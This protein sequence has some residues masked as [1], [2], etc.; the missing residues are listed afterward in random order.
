MDDIS[1]L[2]RRSS[3]RERRLGRIRREGGATNLCGLYGGWLAQPKPHL[4]PCRAARLGTSL[5][6]RE[7]LGR[8][9]LRGTRDHMVEGGRPSLRETLQLLLLSDS[10]KNAIE[11]LIKD[12]HRLVQGFVRS[13]VVTIL[14]PSIGPSVITLVSARRDGP[15]WWIRIY[16]LTIKSKIQIALQFH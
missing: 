1:V 11:D 12:F 15:R 3:L 6:S 4:G 7:G 10:C 5:A 2:L 14:N 9:V 13:P 8:N 16:I